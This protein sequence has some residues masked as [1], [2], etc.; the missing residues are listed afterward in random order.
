MDRGLGRAVDGV[1][2]DGDV[3]QCRTGEKQ[4]GGFTSLGAGHEGGDEEAGKEDWCG[5]VGID[6][7]GDARH[8]ARGGVEDREGLLDS[9]GYKDRVELRVGFKNGRN[10]VWEGSKVGNIPLCSC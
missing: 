2:A 10:A 3:A 4:I 7:R 5:E 1:E 6:L 9:G 8:A